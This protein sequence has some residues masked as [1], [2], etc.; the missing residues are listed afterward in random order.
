VTISDTLR[1][2]TV[3]RIRINMA[4]VGDAKGKVDRRVYNGRNNIGKD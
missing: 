3:L 2:V 1:K 4:V